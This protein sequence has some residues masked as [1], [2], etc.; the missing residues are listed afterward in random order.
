MGPEETDKYIAKLRAEEIKVKALETTAIILCDRV[1]N[2]H[3]LEGLK[4]TCR[5]AYSTFCNILDRE[6]KL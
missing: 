2:E 1:E 4:T 5:I 3:T 6:N